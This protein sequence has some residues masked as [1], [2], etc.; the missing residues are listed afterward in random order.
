LLR[1]A[2]VVVEGDG[3]ETAP[4]PESRHMTAVY[5][6]LRPASLL[7]PSSRIVPAPLASRDTLS[8]GV[9]AEVPV[10]ERET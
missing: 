9:V 3:I 8:C 6:R 10:E 4:S 2:V 5:D 7:L 1:F